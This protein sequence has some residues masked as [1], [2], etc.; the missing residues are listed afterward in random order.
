[1]DMHIYLPGG[2]RVDAQYKGFTI[3]TDQSVTNG[4]EG[5]SPAPFDLFLG[6]L[7]TCAGFY[8]LSFCQE[9]D[10]PTKDISL[11]LTTQRDTE[12]RMINKITIDINLPDDF[13]D[14][15]KNAVRQAADLCAVKKHILHAPEFEIKI[16]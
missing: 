16:S 10:I 12:S 7:G 1:M 5:K 2:K 9:R 11:L 6:S 8:V 3:Q 4:G 14:K 13:P 15:Y